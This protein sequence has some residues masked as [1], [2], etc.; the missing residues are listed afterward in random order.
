LQKAEGLDC[1]RRFHQSTEDQVLMK[2]G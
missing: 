1:D 2:Q